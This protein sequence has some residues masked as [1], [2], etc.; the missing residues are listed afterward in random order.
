MV[1]HL[2]EVRH[3]AI[4]Y[5]AGWMCWLMLPSAPPDCFELD[6]G[7]DGDELDPFLVDADELDVAGALKIADA[8]GGSW[9]D[10]TAEAHGMAAALHVLA[11]AL[12]AGLKVELDA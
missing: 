12:R 9:D 7:L 4:G 6:A 5:R 3:P 8:Y 10:P 11:A 2:T 1:P